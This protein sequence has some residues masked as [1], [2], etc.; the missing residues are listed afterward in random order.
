[1]DCTKYKNYLQNTEKY[2]IPDYSEYNPPYEECDNNK[3]YDNEHNTIY[4]VVDIIDRITSINYMF[5]RETFKALFSEAID[6]T[7][8]MLKKNENNRQKQFIQ[9]WYILIYYEFPKELNKIYQNVIFNIMYCAIDKTYAND[10]NY[11]DKFEKNLVKALAAY[12]LD[13]DTFDIRY[14]SQYVRQYIYKI[15]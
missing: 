10:W 15:K 4:K 13:F 12:A 9:H 6:L 8:Y 7:A 2:I 5:E 1:M 11:G 14:Y 3:Y